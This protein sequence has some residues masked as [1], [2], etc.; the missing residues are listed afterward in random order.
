LAL[1]ENPFDFFATCVVCG[2]VV[3]FLG[4]VVVLWATRL[5]KL[6]ATKQVVNMK[7]MA[8]YLYKIINYGRICK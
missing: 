2:L 3:A 1:I 5:N 6:K 7:R 4:N 8:C